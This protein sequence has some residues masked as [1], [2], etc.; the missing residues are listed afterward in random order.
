MPWPYPDPYQLD[1][2]DNCKRYWSYE[3]AFPDYDVI[4]NYNLRG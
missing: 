4:T 3:S 1:T 2:I